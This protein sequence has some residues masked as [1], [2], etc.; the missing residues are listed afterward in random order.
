MNSSVNK[1]E[2]GNNGNGKPHISALFIRNREN[3]NTM[4]EPDDI[5]NSA[6]CGSIP[7]FRFPIEN[8]SFLC[9]PDSIK[10]KKIS[11]KCEEILS[12]QRRLNHARNL[13]VRANLLL[14]VSV[15]KNYMNRGLPFLDLIQEGNIGLIKAVSK[16]DYRRGYKFSTYATWWIRQSITRAIAENG[17]TIRVPVHLVEA[18]SRIQKCKNI[19]LQ[20]GGTEPSQKELSSELNMSISQ[21]ERVEKLIKTTISLE[22]PLKDDEGILRDLIEDSK[23]ESP[24]N[25]LVEKETNAILSDVMKKLEPREEKIIRMRFGIGHEKEYTLEEVG[26]SLNL[27]RERVRQLEN[28]AVQKLRSP[29]NLPKIKTLAM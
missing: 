2:N 28:K 20:N 29:S 4:C 5:K 1:G 25:M 22:S 19:L 24:V 10:S 8:L 7:G 18:L 13:L 17:R 12:L 15:A 11:S 3:K 6:Q 14:V 27:T 21:I 9:H 23:S 16:F 26:A